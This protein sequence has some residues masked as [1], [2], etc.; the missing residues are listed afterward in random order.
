M[1]DVVVPNG[2]RR[3]ESGPAAVL[4]EAWGVVVTRGRIDALSGDITPPR[5][6]DF[7]LD[8]STDIEFMKIFFV[9]L[10]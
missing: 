7:V 9:I 1:G 3:R 8:G 4:G 10:I 6:L 5:R 2:R